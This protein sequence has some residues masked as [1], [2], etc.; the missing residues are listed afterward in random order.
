MA[1]IGKEKT[2]GYGGLPVGT[3]E[4]ALSLISSGIDSPVASFKMLKRGVQLSYI[5]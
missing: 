5:H 1:L 2:E 4:E 3:G